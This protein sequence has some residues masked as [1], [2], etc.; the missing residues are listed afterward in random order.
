LV[1]FS[2]EFRKK[3]VQE[4]L[5][6]LGSTTLCKKYGVAS[7]QTILD[8]VHRYE[9]FGIEA[10]E[11]RSP[12]FQYDRSF[13]VK[14]LKWRMENKAS[15]T[16]TALH[17]D[18]S[19]VGTISTWEK[20]FHEEG[21]EALNKQRG[22]PKQMIQNPKE[23]KSTKNKLSEL[24]RLKEENKLLKIENE[25]LKKLK[26]LIQEPNPIDKSKHE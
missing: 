20:K 11:V 10:F 19:N 23:N 25:Y 2:S 17:F 9:K 5:T 15:L 16:E 24:E 6:G 21:I 4:Y 26:A 1:R 22:R 14:V 8:W 3:V 12:K 13:K 18:I 7:T